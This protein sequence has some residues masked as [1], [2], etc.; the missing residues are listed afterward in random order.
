MKKKISQP[1]PAPAAV[2][3]QQE[4]LDHRNRIWDL[5]AEHKISYYR[6][7]NGRLLEGDGIRVRIKT[8]Q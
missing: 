5:H 1:L 4:N 2:H 6:R 7:V 3:C 8:T